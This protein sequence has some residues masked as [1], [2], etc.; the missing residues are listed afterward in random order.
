M[1][2]R[3][4]AATAGRHLAASVGPIIAAIS[5]F[6]LALV[7]LH[8]VS[9]G[10][11]GIAAILLIISQLALSIS[12]SLLCAPFQVASHNV[13]NQDLAFH[14]ADLLLAW[15]AGLL[16]AAIGV[17]LGATPLDVGL[18]G[19]YTTI[20]V[21]RWFARAVA[22][23]RGE[24][25]RTIV[26]DL[27]L[28]SSAIACISVMVLFDQVSLRW[29]FGS[30]LLSVSLSTL[31]F[32]RSFL[33][34]RVTVASLRHISQYRTVWQQH[35]RWSLLGVVTT[36]VTVNAHA[37]LVTLILGPAAFA[38]VAAAALLIRPVGLAMNALSDF[39]RPRM[40]RL[41]SA[42]EGDTV[43]RA[44]SEFTLTLM[45]VWFSSVIGAIVLLLW[46]PSAVVPAQYAL[47]DFAI[48]VSLWFVV[49]LVRIL[50]TPAG[51][52]L[53]ASGN[54]RELAHASYASCAVSVV[55]VLGLILW[56]GAIWSVLGIFL[57]EVVVAWMIWKI[58]GSIVS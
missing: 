22:Y 16:T 20:A 14:A 51:V 9:G 34:N 26:S 30:L 1:R 3:R 49:A 48:G 32:G 31:P 5:Q 36:E 15:G 7:L 12:S 19:L 40:A 6:T 23:A 2:A 52:L 38:P 46:W 41:V 42:R 37:Y 33:P 55:T 11:F 57:G 45:L 56:A 47:R 25:M 28:G 53:Q 4:L 58:S 8:G 50:R 10:E 44:M 39:E 27:V 35:S 17:W 54:F 29:A 24:P 13:D 21:F 18:F 43:R